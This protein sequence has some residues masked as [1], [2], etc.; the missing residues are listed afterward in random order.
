[1]SIDKKPLTTQQGEL[2]ITRV[3]DAPVEL[4]YRVWTD[5]V[6]MAKWWGPQGFSN[7]VCEMDVRAGGKIRID[8]EAPD[9]T[10]YSMRGVYL[11][12]LKLEKIV[13]S[14]VSLDQN[15][16]PLFEVVNNITFYTQGKKTKLVIDVKIRRISAEAM[17]HVAG[18]KEGWS[19][20]L[21]RMER[22]LEKWQ[23]PTRREINKKLLM[24]R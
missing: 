1:M 7:P 2:T 20:T 4:V 5:P 18:M 21:S 17:L 19:Q 8:M 11:E 13:F 6:H 12:V 16:Q 15:C 23:E 3:V 10:L 14:S 22:V 9:G 24:M